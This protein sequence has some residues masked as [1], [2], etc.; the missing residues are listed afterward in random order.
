V[1][2]WEGPP[3]GGGQWNFLY[4]GDTETFTQA[5][6]NFA[7]IRAPA[8]DLVL[9]DGPHEN[10]FLKNPNADTRVDWTFTIWVP[11]NWHRLYNNPTSVF[12]ADD[13]NFHKPVDPPRLNVYLGDGGGVDWAEVS[14]PANVRVHDQRASASGVD[15]SGGTVISAEFFDM[16]SAKPISD[17]QLVVERMSWQT[18]LN[19]HWDHKLVAKGVSDASGGIQMK[20]V[21]PGFRL[22]RVTADGYAPR[23]IDQSQHDHP[24]FLKYSVELAKAAS[25]RGIVTGTDGRPIKGATVRAT[26]L[27]GSD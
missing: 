2:W 8:L 15:L 10:I 21:P 12:G 24:E 1:G 5:L 22:I 11:A 19:P 3:F 9:H 16:D 7:A 26:T 6:A 27:L 18:N 14:V 13:P 17:V 4:R 25:L 23:W 20:N